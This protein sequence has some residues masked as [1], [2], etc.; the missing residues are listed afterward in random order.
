MPELIHVEEALGRVLDIARTGPAAFVDLDEAAG[1]V[2]AEEVHADRHYPPFPRSRMDGYAVRAA[3]CADPHEALEVACE[4]PAGKDPGDRIDEGE[5][6][7]VFTGAP[8][9]DGADAVVM[10]EDCTVEER[11]GGARFVRIGKRPA[12]GQFVT[13]MGSEAERDQTVAR[14]GDLLT[15]ARVGALAAVGIHRVAARI[16]PMVRIVATG[17]ELVPIDAT[18]RAGQIRNSNAHA[19]AAAARASGA[20]VDGIAVA[21]DTEEAHLQAIRDALEA[22]VVIITGGVSVGDYD[23]VPR[24]LDRLHV[25]RVFHG[26]RIQ[27]GKPL[28]FGSHK[29]RLVFGLPGNPVS[30]L[31]NFELFVRPAI[32]RFL[33]IEPA[34]EPSRR[35]ELCSAVGAGTWRTRYLPAHVKRGDAGQIVAELVPIQGSGDLFGFTAANGLVVVPIDAPPREPGD[36]VQ[37]IRLGTV[38]S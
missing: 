30:S 12:R 16:R 5:A 25:R 8:V 31:V 17:S 24:C 19:L 11:D 21:P 27:P 37:V 7:R 36:A 34:A 26:V 15:P 29:G 23:L 10:Q 2:L 35:A 22:D 33:G 20:V 6:A 32:R 1:R 3:D 4:I 13:P 14:V 38:L 9:P 18:P 28:W